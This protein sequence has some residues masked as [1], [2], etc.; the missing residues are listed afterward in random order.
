M[1]RSYKRVLSHLSEIWV[2]KSF[3]TRNRLCIHRET[4]NPE[5]GD[6]VFPVQKEYFE[7][8]RWK[9]FRLKKKI[10]DKYYLEIRNILNG[11]THRYGY[12][13]DEIFDQIYIEALN[14]IKGSIP[15]NDTGEVYYFEWLNNKE[16]KKAIKIWDKDPYELLRYLVHQGFIEQ[17]ACLEF[18]RKIAKKEVYWF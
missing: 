14:R 7:I 10:R 11:Y 12:Q 1:S 6:V 2:D 3:R 8:S 9:D 13:P 17:A 16:V 5:Y 15:S 18:R 4:R